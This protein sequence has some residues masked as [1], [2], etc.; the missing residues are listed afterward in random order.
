M[1]ATPRNV[2]QKLGDHEAIVLRV[3]DVLLEDA[4]PIVEGGHQVVVGYVHTG[5]AD[6]EF[7]T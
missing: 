3:L 4:P 2:R 5:S 6:D 1:R 7:S